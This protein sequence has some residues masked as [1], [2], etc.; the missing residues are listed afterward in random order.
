ML[1]STMSWDVRSSS[2]E[3]STPNGTAVRS[4][5]GSAQCR[6]RSS[7]VGSPRQCSNERRGVARSGSTGGLGQFR[8]GERG[9]CPCD[10]GG[11]GRLDERRE[12]PVVFDIVRE[13]EELP[14]SI[15]RFGDQRRAQRRCTPCFVAEGNH[16]ETGRGTRQ[17]RSQWRLASAPEVRVVDDEQREVSRQR[18][19][20]GR[21]AVPRQRCSSRVASTIGPSSTRRW[22]NHFAQSHSAS[23]SGA[24]AITT[25]RSA[26][27]WAVVASIRTVRASAVR[28]AS[29]P[30]IATARS[31]NRSIS[32]TSV[33]PAG[34]SRMPNGMTN[35]PG[36]PGRRCHSVGRAAVASR[37][38]SIA[39]SRGGAPGRSGG[40]L[41]GTVPSGSGGGSRRGSAGGPRSMTNARLSTVR[42]PSSQATLERTGEPAMRT[43]ES[44]RSPVAA[45][46]HH[47]IRCDGDLEGRFLHGGEAEFVGTYSDGPGRSGSARAT[48]CVTVLRPDRRSGRVPRRRADAAPVQPDRWS[49]SSRSAGVPRRAA[50]RSRSFGRRR[51]RLGAPPVR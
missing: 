36:R 24:V 37:T 35:A 30:A 42:T 49:R 38:A 9:Q 25:S 28:S 10:L 2:T 16:P 26:G 19:S 22:G 27:P 5:S 46:C 33:S 11:H 1:R 45:D 50:L 39:G 7:G 31:V 15:G 40:R 20:V 14:T 43:D 6:R 17:Q 8:V 51:E 44:R 3:S 48:A 4:M 21:P 18:S 34:P 41:N 32:T 13:R 23:R 12:H 47:A 29:P